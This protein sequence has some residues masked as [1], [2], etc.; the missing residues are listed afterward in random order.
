MLG[1][2]CAKTLGQG[3]RLHGGNPGPNEM[4]VEAA[5]DQSVSTVARQ[6]P[7]IIRLRVACGL[8]A[9]SIPTAA[10]PINKSNDTEADTAAWEPQPQQACRRK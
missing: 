2:T 8:R 4:D 3:W 1:S 6:I 10:R 5:N 7:M 9:S